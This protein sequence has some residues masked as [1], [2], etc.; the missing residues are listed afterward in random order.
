MQLT[1]F[2]RASAVGAALSILLGL[3]T[4][5]ATANNGRDF[6]GFFDVSDMQKQGDLVQVTLHL[7]LFNAGT[8][9]VK[10][11]V[12]TLVDSDPSMT[13]RGSFV[14]VKVW[15]H[16]QR[17]NLTQQFSVTQREYAE[18]M[19]GPGQPNLVIL[20]E[21]SKG[22]SWHRGAQISRRPLVQ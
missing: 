5:V 2:L 10:S 15:K 6:N 22:N 20:F 1:R 3:T 9:D 12:V 17:I 16:Q 21:D 8:E 14:P 4:V 7:Q 19:K 13:L 18:W 11:V